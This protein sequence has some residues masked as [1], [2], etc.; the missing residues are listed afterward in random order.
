MPLTKPD[1]ALEE[2]AALE[3]LAAAKRARM[4]SKRVD[5][6]DQDARPPRRPAVEQACTLEMA[7]ADLARPQGVAATTMRRDHS[8]AGVSTSPTLRS[9]GDIV[10]SLPNEGGETAKTGE[11]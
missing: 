11:E 1:L 3:L 5:V 9:S 2:R 6:P 8:E 10:T 7:L 4:Q